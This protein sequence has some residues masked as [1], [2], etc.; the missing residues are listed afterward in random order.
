MY[1]ENLLHLI[2]GKIINEPK[3]KKVESATIYPSKVEMGDLFFACN[4]EDISKAVENGAYAVVFE[5]AKPKIEDKEIAYIEVSS[6]KEATIKFLRF[7]LTQ[8]KSQIYYFEDIES[9][10]LK[11]ISSRK[12]SIYTILSDNWQKSFESILN[13]NYDIFITTNIDDAQ[14]LSPNFKSLEEL[15]TG[16]II[17]DSLLKTTFKIEKYIYQNVEIAP[18]FIDNLRKVVKFCQDNDIEY[19]LNRIKYTKEFKPIYVDKDLN[20]LPKGS[21]E[22][23]LIFVNSTK[24]VDKSIEYLRKEGKWIK[25]LVFTP[26]K[27]KLETVDRPIWFKSPNEVKETLKKEH[28]HYAFCYKLEIKDIINNTKEYPALF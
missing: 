25:S 5:G 22:K 17:S 26:P 18:F 11:L 2:D 19:D 8:K 10:F 4:K 3:V 14:T 16:Y 21:S 15:A 28:F 20:A 13:S 6:I 24:I 23:V 27:T 12:S 7:I 9:S 1:I